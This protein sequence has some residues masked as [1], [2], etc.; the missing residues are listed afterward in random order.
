M[1]WLMQTD[2]PTMT[3]APSKWLVI[4]LLLLVAGLT[5]L[6]LDGDSLWVDEHWTIYL[7]GD[8]DEGPLNAAQ[9]W[10]RTSSEDFYWPPGYVLLYAGWREL[11]GWTPLAGR[12]LS[13][14]AGL[15]TVAWTYRL[16]ADVLNRRGGLIAALLIGSSAYFLYFFHELRGYVLYV[17][18]IT[19]T[20]WSYWQITRGHGRLAHY[21]LLFIGALGLLYTN[22]LAALTLVV[23][24]AYHLLFMPKDRRWWAVALTV[25]APGLLFLPWLTVIIDAFQYATGD[26]IRQA[27][28]FTPLQS[29]KGALFMFSSGSVALLAL[30]A[31]YSLRRSTPIRFLW[32]WALGIFALL[33]IVNARFGVILEV[34]YLFPVWPALA[35]IAAA[36][37][38]RL[39]RAHRQPTLIALGL[40]A[41]AGIWNSLDPAA[42]ASMH[43]PHFHLPWR[44]LTAEVRQHAAPQD[45]LA[46]ILPDWTWRAYH[47]PVF[48]Y[49]LHDTPLGRMDLL[50]RPVNVGYQAYVDQVDALIEGGPLLW[51]AFTPEQPTV[52]REVFE[53]V[54]AE[55][56]YLHCARFEPTPS[57]TLDL[58]SPAKP[59]AALAP[60]TFGSSAITLETLT[61]AVAL[62]DMTLTTT[63]IWAVGADVPPYTYSIALHLEDANGAL[64]G[65]TDLGLPE[66]GVHCTHAALDLAGLPRGDYRLLAAVYAWET[67]DRLPPDA[68]MA[69]DD[70]VVVAEIRLP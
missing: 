7:A 46:F 62:N 19:I 34:R 60:V 70:R 17:L 47:T 2:G 33:V 14:L 55:R 37:A 40:W 11:V 36:G 28:A 35:L 10:A 51:A 13:L 50:E 15:L 58:Y 61:A 64:A 59:N 48:E 54:L 12:A 29:L 32:F 53:D 38:D 66:A 1:N 21:A 67:G 45:A 56:A 69:L 23:L 31:A 5:M 24:G 3:R 30:F 18:F 52:Q 4:P 42:L 8:I 39:L 16:G 6:G 20:V 27:N 41:A 9:I 25:A 44:E 63:A 68:P 26:A 43:N 49:Y 57:L 65:Q 22:Y